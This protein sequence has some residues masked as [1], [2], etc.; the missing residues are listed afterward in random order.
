MKTTVNPLF[1]RLLCAAQP[2]DLL[3]RLLL[4]GQ[5]PRLTFLADAPR[6]PAGPLPYHAGSVLDHLA[7]CMNAVAG[8]PPAVWMAL[9][10]DAGKLTTPAALWPHHYGHEL[11]GVR[12]AAVW[13]AQLQLPPAWRQA[14]CM[15]AR[16]HMKA[17]RYSEL[18]AAT[19]YDLLRE[20]AASP[21][22][23]AF[24]QV[25]DADSRQAVSVQARRDWHRICELPLEGLSEERARQLAISCLTANSAEPVSTSPK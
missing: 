14:G 13:A 21:C 25:V 8:N 1:F 12:L 10:H 20:L 11:R 5:G 2:G 9:T 3:R 17:G 4:A 23:S 22:A 7:R 15:T 18:R 16:L 24:W 19:R 6:I